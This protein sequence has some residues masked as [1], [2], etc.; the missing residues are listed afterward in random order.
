[1]G[2]SRPY[3][4]SEDQPEFMWK[5]LCAVAAVLLLGGGFLSFQNKAAYESEMTSRKNYEAD[6]EKTQAILVKTQEELK[7]NENNVVQVEQE[8]EKTKA[9]LTTISVAI[10]EQEQKENQLN[11]SLEQIIGEIASAQDLIDQIGDIE[12]IEKELDGKEEKLQSVSQ[13]L[14]SAKNSLA[15]AEDRRAALQSRIDGYLEK[16]REQL[17]GKI[18]GNMSASISGVYDTWGFVVINAGDRQ[19]VVPKAELDVLRQ[20]SPIARLQ[21]TTVEPG[22]SVA[23]IVPGSL[24][25][26]QSV[27][28]GDLV[29]PAKAPAPEAV[30]G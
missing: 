22:I 18:S 1:M 11:D 24:Q 23:S 27:Q 25:E 10:S 7:T 30:E 26:G 4:N 12:A 5:I 15:I 8:L 29:V 2:E 13:S 21:V 9:D 20:G 3:P 6:I 14:V 28:A 16:E 19:G 17:S